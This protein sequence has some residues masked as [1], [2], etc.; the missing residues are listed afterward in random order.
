MTYEQPVQRRIG[1]IEGVIMLI[2]LLLS[3]IRAGADTGTAVDSIAVFSFRHTS[4]QYNA[5]SLKMRHDVMDTFSRL[6]RFMPV[7]EEQVQK[8]L[9]DIPDGAGEDALRSTAEK[10]GA[11]LYAVVSVLPVGNYTVGTIVIN[12]VSDRFKNMKRA[13]SVRSMVLMNVPLKIMREIALLH[14]DL[15][16]QSTVIKKK[17]DLFLLGAGQWQGL[18]PG[19]YRTD[20]GDP[21]I[22]HTCGRFQSLASLPATVAPGDR[23]AI[24]SYPSVKGIVREIRERIDYNT[25]YKY[26]ISSSGAQG[27]D[28]EKKFAQGI[29]LINPGTNAC[30]PGYGSFLSTSYLGFRQT[31]PSIPGIVFSSLLIVT[32]FLLPEYMTGFKINF[33]PGVMDRDKT[34]DMNNLQIFLWST[35]PV[36][37]SVAYLDQLAHQFTANNV[38]P[39]FF[40]NRNEAALVLSTLIPGGGL[41]YKGHR[42]PGWSFYLSEMFLAGFCVYTKDDHKKVMWGGITL[43]AVKFIEL[44][45]AYFCKPSFFFFNLEQEGAISQ[46]SLS[47]NI[48]PSGSGEPLYRVG[49]SL[50]Y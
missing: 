48:E 37:A 7:S 4:I 47:L 21:V 33:F 38:L 11:D 41:F 5:L 29:C 16:V 23:I 26:G 31:T 12:P 22:I 27:I 2:V 49:M 15:P 17:D 39:P 13:I 9:E 45:T 46:A 34:R 35:L 3:S 28:H 42:L 14:R 1:K 30:I 19:R 36:T 8:A 20:R 10:L 43:G 44:V 25:N 6:G 18:S 50:R 32:H 40:M 24:R